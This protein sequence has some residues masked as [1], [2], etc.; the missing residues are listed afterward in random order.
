MNNYVPIFLAM[1]LF[2]NIAVNVIIVFFIRCETDKRR[3]GE[4]FFHYL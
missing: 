2:F 3:F 4:I 1:A